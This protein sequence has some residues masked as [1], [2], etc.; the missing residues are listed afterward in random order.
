M[1]DTAWAIVVN[2]T[3]FD[4]LD[5]LK[6]RVSALCTGRGWPEPRWYETTAE[7]PGTGQAAE[8]M[9]DGAALVCPLGGDGTVRA[10]ATAMLDSGVPLGLLPGGTGNLL[11]RNLGLP[12][13]DLDAAL[14]VAV[15]GSDTGVDAGMVA[16]DEREPEVFLVMAGMGL[17]AE[18]VAG[19]SV[20][21]KRQ[22]GWVA[23]ALSGLKGLVRSGFSVRVAAGGQRAFSQHAATV[24][25]GNCGELTAGVRLMPDARVD[26]GLLDVAVVSPRSLGSWFAVG[27][28]I[29]TRHRFGHSAIAHLR[30]PE[31]GIVA[32]EPIDAQLD[33][34]GVGR[35]TAVTCSVR[36]GALTVRV[37]A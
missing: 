11:A 15:T 28:Y 27:A 1:S 20:Q 9:Q 24:M 14:A 18:A 36:P 23:Y 7:D 35:V 33:G 29:L 16:F 6:R 30:G 31:V 25:I 5:A 32:A 21:L 10:V 3:K 13:D 4:D 22:F 17:D 37:P 12:I 26:D 34:D 8:A 19:A 2:P